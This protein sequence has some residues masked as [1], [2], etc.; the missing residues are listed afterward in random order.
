MEQR[1]RGRQVV[2]LLWMLSL[3]I[4]GWPVGIAWADDTRLKPSAVVPQPTPQASHSVIPKQAAVAPADAGAY[5]LQPATKP[6]DRQANKTKLFIIL[7]K[8]FEGQHRVAP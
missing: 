6:T 4:L 1:C 2:G 8:L 5:P 7:L 3:L